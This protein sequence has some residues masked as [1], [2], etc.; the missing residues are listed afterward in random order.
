[1]ATF[2]NDTKFD[3]IF[4]KALLPLI[5][6]GSCIEFTVATGYVGVPI[7]KKMESKLLAIAR[8]GKCR[9]VVGMIFHEGCTQSTKDYLEQLDS[10]LRAVNPISGIFV[11][12]F[13]YH[14]K[15][16]KVVNNLSTKVFIGSSNFST[17]SW[18]NRKE[19]NIDVDEPQV[20]AKTLAFLEYILSHKDTISLSK[21]SLKIK[22]KGSKKVSISKNLE[23]YAVSIAT[24]NALPNPV[25][26]F[27]HRLR[28]DEN[29]KSGLNLYFGRGRL[30]K[31]TRKYAPRPWLEIELA[32][33]ANE[34]NSQ[35][36]PK[37]VA[38]PDRSATSK[39]RIGDFVAYLK[40]GD[41]VYKM[42]MKVHSDNGKNISSANSSGGR[43]TLG[44]YIKGKLQDAGVLAD[45][46]IVTSQTLSDYGRD[47]VT[48]KKINNSTY[49]I[50]FST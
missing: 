35:H 2:S 11:T 15:V 29:P 27:H 30:D 24:Y 34:Y 20:K 13:S 8:S 48:F 4:Q 5:S 39:A 40:D 17:A 32:S 47:T 49:I 21:H 23:D 22:A 12:R 41:K 45:S 38:K 19:F 37:S 46:E 18:N 33:N 9:I 3:S 25:G 28:V 43:G 42:D 7:L 44:K 6:K 1:M 14:G 50:D 16:Y 36:Y 26:Q 31:A 10:R